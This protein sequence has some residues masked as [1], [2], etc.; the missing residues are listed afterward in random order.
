[1]TVF[2][3]NGIELTD[4]FGV[5]GQSLDSAYDVQ[6]VE[7]FSKIAPVLPDFLETAVLTAL[8]EISPALTNVTAYQGAC[9]DGTYIYQAALGRNAIIK[10]K[11]ADGSYTLYE[12]STSDVSIGHANDMTYNPYT[13]LVYVATDNTDGSILAFNASNMSFVRKFIA[14]DGDYLPATLWQLFFDRSAR[15]FYA[16]DGSNSYFIYD[17]SFRY[18]KTVEYADRLA[19]TA[20]EDETDGTYIYRIT[21]NPDRIQVLDKKS[22]AEVAVIALPHIA[23]PESLSYDWNGN[24]YITYNGNG[25]NIFYSAVLTEEA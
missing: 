2:D 4:V 19:A 15:Q 13:G 6:G 7:I 11:I 5:D 17:E 25:A 21:Y 8:E 22:K 10:Y 14:T 3:L 24:W 16:S 23:E 9:T 18:L 20:Q 1:M 12:Y